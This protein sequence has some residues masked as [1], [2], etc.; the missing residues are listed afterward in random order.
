M[1]SFFLN[2]RLTSTLLRLTCLII[3]AVV[4]AA[5]LVRIPLAGHKIHGIAIADIFIG[6]SNAVVEVMLSRINL[7]YEGVHSRPLP[8]ADALVDPDFNT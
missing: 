5:V 2:L 1:C 8:R 3:S 6:V 7:L 4:W